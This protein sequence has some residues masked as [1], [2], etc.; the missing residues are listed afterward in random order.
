M[1]GVVDGN[2]QQFNKTKMELI[3]TGFI[4][5][6][7]TGVTRNGGQGLLLWLETLLRKSFQEGSVIFGFY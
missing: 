2:N 7:K 1:N 6:D 4:A 5:P 3:R